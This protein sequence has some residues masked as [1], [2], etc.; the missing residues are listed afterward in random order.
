MFNCEDKVEANIY[1]EN[2]QLLKLWRERG[3]SFSRVIENEI[4]LKDH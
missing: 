2:S 4:T 3:K 1:N